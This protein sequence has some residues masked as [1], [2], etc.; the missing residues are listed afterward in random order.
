M[1]LLTGEPRVVPDGEAVVES[2]DARYRLRRC[3]SGA[4]GVR[5]TVSSLDGAAVD[6]DTVRRMLGGLSPFLLRRL[7]AISFRQPAP[8]I[9]SLLMPSLP[10]GL[11]CS[12]PEHRRKAKSAQRSCWHGVTRWPRSW[13][14]AGRRRPRSPDPHAVR[15]LDRL[16]GYAEREAA[17]LEQRFRSVE[18]VLYGNGHAAA[19][20]PAGNERRPDLVGSGGDG[21]GRSIGGA[22]CSDRSL[23]DGAVELAGREA[24]V[25]A[26]LAQ[27]QPGVGAATATV[28]DEQAWLAV[29]R[30]LAADLSG[31][32]AR[33]ARA[34]ASEQCV[35]RDA[36][37][38]LRPIVETFQRQLDVLATLVAER[39]Q[40]LAS[41]ELETE[42][43][44]LARSQTELGRQLEY[45]LDRRQTVARGAQPARRIVRGEATPAAFG[46]EAEGVEHGSW[47]TAADAEQLEQRR[48]EL[49]QQR[50]DLSQR[51]SAQDRVLRD[52]RAQRA[53][54]DRQRAGA[55]FGTVD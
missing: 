2:G 11:R 34:S 16:I 47:F 19:V 17:A 53:T 43:G 41:A 55:A 10:A 35:C 5:L 29:A 18:A 38:R 44:H 32:V 37:P 51:L 4:A 8:Q 22:G 24:T 46:E 3:Q 23:A 49:E 31:E 6:H 20:S 26:R 48:L 15:E 40:E 39:Q 33:L 52:L 1:R 54:V 21:L 45:L 9:E 28:I 12:A 30:Q 25:R 50:F 13:S 36:H 7:C 27:V 14:T 42:V